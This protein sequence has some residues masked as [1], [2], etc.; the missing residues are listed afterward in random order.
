MK[1]RPACTGARTVTRLR[2]NLNRGQRFAA[3][4]K[5]S[6]FSSTCATYGDQDGVV[7]DEPLGSQM[8][9]S[10]PYGAFKAGD[11]NRVLEKF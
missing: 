11:L 10:T 2:L 8:P 1:D 4:C 6:F 3:G 7:L 5:S 9:N